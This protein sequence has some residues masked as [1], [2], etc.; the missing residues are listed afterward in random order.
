MSVIGLCDLCVIKRAT[1]V[2][3]ERSS[4]T[5]RVSD[6]SKDDPS[7]PCEKQMKR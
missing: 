4:V 5:L 3:D 1:Y 7:V 2:G 6:F